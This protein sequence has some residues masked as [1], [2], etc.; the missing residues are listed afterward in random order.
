MSNA[1]ALRPPRASPPLRFRRL[2]PFLP[3]ALLAALLL[4]PAAAAQDWMYRVRPG[5][6]L[7]DLGLRHLKPG[8]DWRRLQ[9]HNAV[10]DPYRLPPGML[11]RF[12]VAWLR[13]EP[14][15]ARVIALRGQVRAQAAA[16]ARPAD[17]VEDLRLGV[18]GWLETGADASA[19]IE[20]ADGSRLT[21]DGGSRVE[22]DRLSVYA[23]TGMV[24][25]RMRLQR[26][27]AAN[28]V[29]PAQGPASRYIIATPSATTSVRGTRFRV[30][31]GAGDAPDTAEVLEGQ[32]QVADD[33]RGVLLRPGFGTVVGRDGAPAA[34]ALL[35]APAL[36]EAGSRLQTLPLTLRW[37]PLDGARAYR[38]EVVRADAPEVQLYSA[39]TEATELRIDAL[40]GGRHRVLLR[41]IAGNGLEGRDAERTIA[42]SDKPLPPL[43]VRPRA[44]ER[45]HQ[46]RPRF[47]WTRSEDASGTLIQIA[48]D[49]DFDQPLLESQ[50][51]RERFRPEQALA[52]GR[53][54]WRLASRDGE[55][56]TGP[57]GEALAFEVSDA[58]PDPGLESE[59]ARAGRVVLRWQA[60]EPGQRHRVQVARRPDFAAPLFDQVVDRPQVELE[61]PLGGRWYI[62]VQTVDDDGYAAPYGPVQ[63]LR[64]PCR[65]CY[66]AGAAALLLLAL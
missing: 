2:S 15:R 47:E 7:W 1:A 41:G 12:P 60:G 23:A 6:N 40:P 55:G 45:V 28:R 63:E 5:D 13:V 42:V 51:R 22:F 56:R 34:L 14:V 48:R 24:D 59:Q 57:F 37:A 26:G 16:G 10:Q 21:V 27:R 39:V 25:T 9:A 52:P 8:I 17:A 61:R 58:P 29:T 66:G 32:V 30:G 18:G 3:F 36:D 64:F 19:T 43:T 33:R 38:V 49:P 4:A 65:L 62:R 44:G 31:A 11:L 20:F 50:A 53:Y 35:P 54:Y 46:P